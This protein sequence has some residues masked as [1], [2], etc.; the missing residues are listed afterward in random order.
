M[1]TPDW[2]RVLEELTGIARETVEE[3]GQGA[4]ADLEKYALAMASDW[5]KAIEHPEIV[6]ELKAQARLLAEKHR[7]HVSRAAHVRL[8]QLTDIVV[9]I[10]GGLIA[11]L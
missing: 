7:V 8:A 1:A 2:S 11:A 5:V 9:R 3:L 4:K 6:P 10:G